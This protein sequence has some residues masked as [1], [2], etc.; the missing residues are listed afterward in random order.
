MQNSEIP[1]MGWET[2]HLYKNMNNE[3]P[4]LFDY[5]GL[6]EWKVGTY[7]AWEIEICQKELTARWLFA[8]DHGVETK[9]GV[10]PRPV[11]EYARQFYYD[12]VEMPAWEVCAPILAARKPAPARRRHP[13]LD[14]PFA[15]EDYKAALKAQL[16]AAGE[17]DDDGYYIEP[18]ETGPVAPTEWAAPVAPATPVVSPWQPPE[19]QT[20]SRPVVDPQPTAATPSAIAA[21]VPL[22]A[23]A[24]VAPVPKAAREKVNGT[25]PAVAMIYMVYFEEHGIIK[26]GRAYKNSRWR[27]LVARGAELIFLDRNTIAKQ[28]QAALSLLR[29]VFPPAFQSENDELAQQLLPLGRGFTECFRVASVDEFNLAFNLYIQGVDSHAAEAAEVAAEYR[30]HRKAARSAAARGEVYSGGNEDARRRRGALQTRPAPNSVDDLPARS[31]DERGRATVTPAAADTE[32]LAACV[33]S[34]GRG[35]ASTSGAVA[36]SSARE[37]VTAGGAAKTATVGGTSDAN[38][39]ADNNSGSTEATT[40]AATTASHAANLADSRAG[41]PT[42]RRRTGSGKHC[43]GRSAAVRKRRA[44]T[45]TSAKTTSRVL[46]AASKTYTGASFSKPAGAGVTVLRETPTVRYGVGVRSVPYS[47]LQLRNATGRP[48]CGAGAALNAGHES[49]R[50]GRIG[51]GVEHRAGYYYGS[52][53]KGCGVQSPAAVPGRAGDSGAG[54]L[55]AVLDSNCGVWGVKA[56]NK[57]DFVF[58]E[59]FMKSSWLWRERACARGSRRA[60]ARVRARVRVGGRQF[61]GKEF[62][63][64]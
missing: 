48:V 41:K 37:T 12:L 55:G 34:P 10:W 58:H 25:M 4:L 44:N 1:L 51:R 40:N 42:G 11:P 39:R 13:I 7:A 31:A 22:Q 26:V 60:S 63:S 17:V 64:V 50:D 28:E 43:T 24:P 62:L 16:L 23:P 36:S 9:R 29:Q 61:C 47:T 5:P 20:Q 57:R 32:R 15:S 33:S 6:P 3:P 19:E 54:G 21:T 30:L 45:R 46:Q 18:T 59:S 49:G 35:M 53:Y 56:V 38:I 52:G 27:S 14:S 8:R 2:A